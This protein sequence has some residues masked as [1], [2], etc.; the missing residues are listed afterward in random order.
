[1]KKSLSKENPLKKSLWIGLIWALSATLCGLYCEVFLAKE[2][3]PL[4]NNLLFCLNCH[5]FCAGTLSAFGLASYHESF[6][7]PCHYLMT[8]LKSLI[9]TFSSWFFVF[10]LI[11]CLAGLLHYDITQIS[12]KSLF[13]A[14]FAMGWIV[15]ALRL[16]QKVREPSEPLPI[17]LST[18]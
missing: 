16:F 15:L 8:P 7:L 4:L 6:Q 10:T 1:M 17:R 12:L 3:S 13:I 18:S 11:L 9:R 5:Q 2:P 14:C